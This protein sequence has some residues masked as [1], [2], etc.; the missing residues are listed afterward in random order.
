MALP[1]ATSGELIDIRPLGNKLAESPSTAF[2][3]T[4]DFELMRM[5]LPKG[6]SVPEHHVAGEITMQ[7]LEGAVE[8]Q[9]HSSSHTLLPGYLMYLQGDV[10]HALH[11]LEDSSILVTMLRKNEEEVRS[12]H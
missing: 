8:V 9:A 5:V 4:D 10:P 11:A 3:R 6:K 12:S 7:C 2:V 1:H